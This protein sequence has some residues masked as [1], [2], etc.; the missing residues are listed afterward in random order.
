MTWKKQKQGQ[1]GLGRPKYPLNF[2][3]TDIYGHQTYK[4]PSEGP[5]YSKYSS[6]E[7]VFSKAIPILHQNVKTMS[8]Y[9][10]WDQY[11]KDACPAL[12]PFAA[13]L[14]SLSASASG[15]EQNWSSFGYMHGDS[16]NRLGTKRANDL[17]WLYSNLRLAQRTQSLEQQ[18]M[19]QP[20][21]V[22]SEE[23]EE[24]EEEEGSSIGGDFS[25]ED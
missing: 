21:V 14:L 22:L 7:G 24:E 12:Q 17:V 15:C 16:R 23:E 5:Q 18:D 9:A 6:R 1:G 4:P 10:W 19:A 20:W 8:P 11:G 25:D 13:K 2:H 3:P